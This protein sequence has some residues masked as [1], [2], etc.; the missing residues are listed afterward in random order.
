HR[1]RIARGHA[2]YAL[3]DQRG[4]PADQRHGLA[5]HVRTHQRAVGVVVLKKWN[6]AGR[7][8]NKLLRRNVDVVHFLALLQN[9]VAG[10]AAVDQFG[11]NVLA[12]IERGVGLG[13]HVAVLLP[14]G[15]VEA[16]RV[17]SDLAALELRVDGFDFV[18]LD[19][20]AGLEL[21]V[22]GVD[23]QHVV[24]DAPAL[25]LAIGRL[26][27]AELVDPRVAGKRADQADVR[28]FRSFDRADAAVVRRVDVANLEPGAFPRQ[29]A[30]P[31]GRQAPLVRDFAERIG[32]IHELRQLRT[33]EKFADRRH[34]RLGVDQIVRHGGGHFLVHR[35]FFFDGA[36]HADQADAELVLEELAHRADAAIAQMIDV[37]HRAD[38]L[39]QLEQVPDGSDKVGRVEGSRV[40]RSLQAE[41]DVELQPAHAAEIVFARVEEHAVKQGRGRLERRRISRAQLSID[42]NQG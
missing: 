23:D 17:E 32:L 36:L 33:P 4:F 6:Q 39:A 30:R 29:P 25:D 42:L 34:D 12:L 7:N 38:V 21:A 18:A 15:Q 35:H 22:A 13:D 19:N 20:L 24:D 14:R 3:A 16:V 26:D 31:Q 27:E 11:G 10:L 40:K 1:A 28:S 8:R 5:L 2:L 37:V 9:E 41:F